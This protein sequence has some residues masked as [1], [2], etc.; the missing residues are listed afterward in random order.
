MPE[1]SFGVA[2]NALVHPVRDSFFPHIGD[3]SEVLHSSL[4][5]S[6]ANNPAFSHGEEGATRV[7]VQKG[8]TINLIQQA[9]QRG[10]TALKDGMLYAVATTALAEDRLGNQVSCQ[11]H[12]DGLKHLIRLRGGRKSLRKNFPLCGVLAWVEISVSNCTAP[13][14]RS[15]DSNAT[16]HGAKAS[17][18]STLEARD[19]EEIFCRFLTRLQRVQLS[20]RRSHD[21]V[22]HPPLR[23]TDFLFRKGSPLLIMLGDSDQDSGVITSISRMNANNCQLACLF[24]INFML[25][26]FHGFPQL[27]TRFL[28]RLSSLLRQHGDDKIP[29]ASLF[30]WVFVREIVQDDDDGKDDVDRFDWLIQMIRV[31]RRLGPESSQMLHQALLD[32]L[33]IHEP[34]DAGMLV[35]NDLGIVASRV[36]MGSY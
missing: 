2:H 36:E 8:K 1:L 13:L 22:D 18:L 21:P 33:K 28:V 12:L 11:I 15:Q 31:A 24:Y 10:Q 7:L 19:E 6:A 16:L 30:V 17:S 27:T 23:E 20:K 26:E 35:S 25:C 3:S 29:R 14:A 9:L 4:L 5:I 32:S 34:E